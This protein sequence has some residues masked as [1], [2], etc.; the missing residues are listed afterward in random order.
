MSTSAV[1]GAE[2]ANLVRV[3]VASGERVNDLVLPSR[4][5]LAEILPD[6]AALVGA[7]DPYE[8]HE[9]FTLV[10]PDGR[11]LDPDT[12]L[13]AQG[14]QDGVLLS[15]VPGTGRAPGKVYDDLVEAV[16]DAV[17][18]R[19][20]GWGP[21]Q[22]RASMLAGA[23]AL[24][25]VGALV[26]LLQRGSGGLVPAVAG[27][28]TLLLLLAG[29]VFAR[30][31][32]D[33][34]AAI[35]VL[36]GAAAYGVVTALTAVSGEPFGLP[37]L[38]AGLILAALGVVATFVLPQ[39]G[40]TF[41]PCL[42]LGFA[43]AGLGVALTLAPSVSP[44]RVLAVVLVATVL[45][46]SLIPWFALSTVR[47]LPPPMASETEILADPLAIDPA[48]VAR[49][50]GRAHEVS[51]GLSVSVAVLVV[52][53]APVVVGLGWAG[54]A[55]VGAAGVAQVLRTRQVLRASEVLVGLVGG[56]GAMAT[57]TV[58]AVLAHPEWGGVIGGV[59]GVSAIGVLA[60]LAT[61]P[62]SSVRSARLLDL[63][64][65]AVLFALV[66]LLVVAAGLLGGH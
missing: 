29:A 60:V 14:V 61:P 38:V 24:L 48:R 54:L 49:E 31:R 39:R 28:A 25:A 17:E 57:G 10:Q 6:L 12:S 64:E 20:G 53:A 15:L 37:L 42:V 41:V 55:L 5:P 58:A 1:P 34:P 40:W 11:A 56:A 16:A 22:A 7:L 66:P 51:L 43:A 36:A 30:I 62:G 59:A 47:A 4:L 18:D 19:S 35:V 2:S 8:V 26:L 63:A 65:A 50:V 46:T 32:D 27:A 21:D 23:G 44:A 3:S 52:L 33:R 9:G 45:A 13:L